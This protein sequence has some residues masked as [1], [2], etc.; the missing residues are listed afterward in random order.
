MAPFHP[1]KL[2]ALF[3]LDGP[4]AANGEHLVLQLD[5][6]VVARQAGQ[7]DA[8]D[9][10]VGGLVEVDGR[11]PAGRVVRAEAVHPFVQ[12]EQVVERIPA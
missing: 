3:V 10:A 11:R 2:R 12:R 4:L 7:L 5:L 9:E 1:V 6:D 8:E